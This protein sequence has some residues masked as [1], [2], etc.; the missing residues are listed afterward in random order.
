LLGLETIGRHDD[1]FALGGHSLLAMKLIKRMR[2]QGLPANLRTLF[3]M[4]TLA[5]LA[6]QTFGGIQQDQVESSFAKCK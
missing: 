5:A 2:Q 3:T 1:F 4:R 6:T